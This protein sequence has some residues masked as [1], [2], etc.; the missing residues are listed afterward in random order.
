MRI[1]LN[2]GRLAARELKVPT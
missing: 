1:H 2:L